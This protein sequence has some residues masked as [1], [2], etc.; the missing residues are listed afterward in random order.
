MQMTLR[1]F[2]PGDAEALADVYRDAVRGIGPQAYSGVQVAAWALYPDDLEEFRLRMSRGLTLVA[3]EGARLI[4]F[5]QLEPD[6][7]LSFLYCSS[8]HARRGIASVIYSAL[9]SHAV[10]R[11]VA[12]IRAEASRISRPFFES[13]GY[14]VI[15]IER[16]IR[17]E[18]EFE[19]FRMLKKLGAAGWGQR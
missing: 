18:M 11:G 2:T 19:R 15:G 9:E 16:V 1:S 6:D 14:A 7:H 3:E 4:A 13:K 17:H 10:A 12:E 8:T 5:G